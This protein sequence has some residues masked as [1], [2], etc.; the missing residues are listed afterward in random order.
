MRISTLLTLCL[1]VFMLMSVSTDAFAAPSEGFV[2]MNAGLVETDGGPAIWFDYENDGDLDILYGGYTSDALPVTK[3][4]R[5]DQGRFVDLGLGLMSTDS[6]SADAYDFDNDDDEDLLLTGS[7]N[8][9]DMHYCTKIYR[10]QGGTLEE[11]NIQFPGVIHSSA[12]WGDYNGDGFADIILTGNTGSE[13]ITRLYKNQAG[14]SFSLVPTNIARVYYGDV[15]WGDFDRDGDLD[16]VVTGL[17]STLTGEGSKAPISIIYRNDRGFFKEHTRRLIGVY[18]SSVS[19]GDYDLDD[20]LDLL[21]TGYYSSGGFSLEPISKVYKN[22]KGSFVD[23]EIPIV[24]AGG[25]D[26]EWVDYDGDGDLDIFLTGDEGFVGTNV[27][28]K[29]YR[30]D[31]GAFVDI[32]ADLT[33]VYLGGATCGDFDNDGDADVLLTGLTIPP[34][35]QYAEQFTEVFQN[36]D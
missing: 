1:T 6:G 24:Q 2:S 11:M 20:D 30:N 23:A 5:N 16:L 17:Q 15:A 27:Y 18:Y 10:N 8:S 28:S 31:R 3:L 35:G 12:K 21:L 22:N 29:I 33:P 9:N 25:G 19:F 4:Y 14:V 32:N 26:S 34:G 7:C 36:R 13:I